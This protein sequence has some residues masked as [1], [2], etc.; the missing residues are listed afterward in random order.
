MTP[1]R[2]LVLA[3]GPAHAVIDLGGSLVVV[4][5][6]ALELE[7]ADLVDLEIVDGRSFVVLEAPDLT[8]DDHSIVILEGNTQRLAIR[9]PR[10]VSLP[11]VADLRMVKVALEVDEG[12]GPTAADLQR[13]DPALP[14]QS[15]GMYPP[16]SEYQCGAGI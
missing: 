11:D 15:G 14:E 9:V 10:S 8:S 7:V 6:Q 3:A 2:G 5:P 16:Q 13:E 1:V 12:F 4:D